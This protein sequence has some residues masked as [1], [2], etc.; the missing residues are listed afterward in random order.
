MASCK[1]CGGKLVVRQTKNT[2]DRQK[3]QYYYTAYYF[4]TVCKKM[5]LSDEFKVENTHLAASL[6]TSDPQED[7]DVEIWTDGAARHNGQP[8]AK[9]AWAFVSSARGGSSSGRGKHEEVGLVTGGKQT[10]NVAEALAIYYGLKWASGEGYRKIRL[11]TDSQI[12]LFN[13][14]KPVEKIVVNREIFAD[15]RRVMQENNLDVQFV[16]VLGHAGDM[17]NERA[18]KLANALAGVSGS[19][20]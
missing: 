19:A 16:K 10:N 11:Y 6:F 20:K 15:I 9:A 5:F 17:N 13:L 3:K 4:C 1:T 18:D 12:S 7:V 8:N 2:P 14:V